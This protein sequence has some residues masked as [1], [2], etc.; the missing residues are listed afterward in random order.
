MVLRVRN[1]LARSLKLKSCIAVEYIAQKNLIPRAKNDLKR[2]GEE[3]SV[4]EE[5][6][7]GGLAKIEKT[8][9]GEL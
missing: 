3:K 7:R 1:I 9:R 8:I 6:G 5:A 2:R 4:G